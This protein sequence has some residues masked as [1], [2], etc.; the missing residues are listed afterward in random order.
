MNKPIK[1]SIIST[2]VF[3]AAYIALQFIAPTVLIQ[4]AIHLTFN[5]PARVDV[6]FYKN[7]RYLIILGIALT[8]FFLL[9]K[10]IYWE[11]LASSFISGLNKLTSLFT[12]KILF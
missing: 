5:T 7:L 12:L 11:K 6:V 1:I 8:L 4:K 3:I 2:L 9:K 10:S